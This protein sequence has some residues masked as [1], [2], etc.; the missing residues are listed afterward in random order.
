[1]RLG[2]AGGAALRLT[3]FLA[4]FGIA[5][6]TTSILFI[7]GEPSHGPGEHRFPE[8]CALLADAL[9]QSGLPVRAEVSQGW[10][11]DAKLAAAGIVVLYSDGLDGHVANGKTAALRKHIAAKKGLAVLHFALEPSKGEL[12]DFLLE[13]IG[14]RFEEGWSVNPVWKMEQPELPRHAVTRGVKPF[15]IDDEWYYHLRF[16]PGV[17]PVLQALPS[18]DTL[19]QDGP[20]SGNPTVRA[21]LAKKQLQTLGW[22]YEGAGVRTFGFTGGH[23]HRNWADDNFRKLVLNGIVWTAAVDVPAEGVRSKVSPMPR[24]PTIDE[25]IARGDLDDVKLH[26]ATDPARV[27]RGPEAAM[28]PLHQAILRNRTEIALLLLERGADVNEPD[29]SQRTPLHLAVERASVP[30]VEAL[31]ARKAKPHERDRM[32]WTPL[33]HAAAKDRVAVAKALM[34]GGANPSTLSE[35][36]GTALHEAAASG[37]AEMIQMFLD[38]KV[39]PKVVSK[40]GVTALDIAK[41]FKNEVA[42]KMLEPLTPAKK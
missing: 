40:L 8:G 21:A 2:L 39:D 4:A 17:T 22:V 27:K 26:L 24:Y 14:G 28:S 3:L 31:L 32:G 20:R 19:G 37:G 5:N 12:S 18:P 16:R 38:A 42:I 15:A 34:K 9:N 30:L 23:Y 36:G 35:R 41:E 7:A 13:T 1:M 33:H 29:R 6:A 10:P 25:S 11:D